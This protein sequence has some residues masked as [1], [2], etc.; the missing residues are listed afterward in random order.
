[1][2]DGKFWGGKCFVLCM[3]RISNQVGDIKSFLTATGGLR[4]LP[5]GSVERLILL[6]AL[7]CIHCGQAMCAVGS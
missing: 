1:M 3:Q 5:G 2:E 6:L 4:N 7:L